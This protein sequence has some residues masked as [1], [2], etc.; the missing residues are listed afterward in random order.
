MRSATLGLNATALRQNTWRHGEIGGSPLAVV[1]HE[2]HVSTIVFWRFSPDPRQAEASG[3]SGLPTFR[4][5][6][7]R[8]R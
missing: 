3:E 8:R 5:P 4:L 1:A 2:A 6:H 7:R